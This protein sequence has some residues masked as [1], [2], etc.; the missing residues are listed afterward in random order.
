MALSNR[1]EAT[2]PVRAASTP[3][4][5]S[6]HIA[7]ERTTGTDKI[8]VFVAT[9]GGGARCRRRLDRAGSWCGAGSSSTTHGIVSTVQQQIHGC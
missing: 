7:R 5:L 8:F 2:A 1:E 9:D 3:V 4:T 6:A